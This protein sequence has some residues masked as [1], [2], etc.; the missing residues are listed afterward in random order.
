MI[1]IYTN[2]KQ[3]N[4]YLIQLLKKKISFILKAYNNLLKSYLLHMAS[5]H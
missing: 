2:N 3:K 4:L 1:I 5:A